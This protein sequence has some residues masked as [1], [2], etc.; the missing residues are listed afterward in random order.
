MTAIATRC[1][2]KLLRRLASMMDQQF[3]RWGCDV[4]HEAGNLLVEYGGLIVLSGFST[5]MVPAPC[6]MQ[7]RSRARLEWRRLTLVFGDDAEG[8]LACFGSRM[9]PVAGQVQILGRW[10]A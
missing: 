9:G 7:S 3:W 2:G 6:C 10:P 1:E 5:G 4:K 8:S